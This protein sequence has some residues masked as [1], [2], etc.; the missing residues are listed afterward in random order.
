M[1]EEYHSEIKVYLSS[2]LLVRLR[3]SLHGPV[4]LSQSGNE[5]RISKLA[6]KLLYEGSVS[7]A[8]RSIFEKGSVSLW[9]CEP[10]HCTP[11]EKKAVRD[12]D[13]QSSFHR[14]GPPGK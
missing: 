10:R 6:P 7:R 13:I 8:C 9:T 5:I 3:V 11:S 14:P 1:P 12:T 4:D 2:S